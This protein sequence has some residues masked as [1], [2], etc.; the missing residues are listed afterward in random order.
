MTRLYRSIYV[1]KAKGGVLEK[2]SSKYHNEKIKYKGETFDSRKEF[3][4]YLILKDREKRGEIYGLERQ[5]SIEIQ[6]SFK[7]P[8]GETVRAITYIADF[9]YKERIG[10]RKVDDKIISDD[11]IVH[12]VDV[13]GYKTEIY[14]LKKKLLAYKGIYIEEV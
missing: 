13:K 12:V 7:T 1:E 10:S 2:S 5:K 8:D 9:V 11:I 14:K 6:P 4:Y 3:D